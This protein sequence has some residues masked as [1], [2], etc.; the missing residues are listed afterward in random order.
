[1]ATAVKHT[2]LELNDSRVVRFRIVSRAGVPVPI[3]SPGFSTPIDTL[4]MLIN[5]ASFDTD[6]EQSVNPVKTIGGFIILHWGHMPDVI[7]AS[8]TTPA[9]YL[10]AEDIKKYTKTLVNTQNNNA[11]DFAYG[12]T[13]I[14]REFTAGYQNYKK[15][16][17]IFR[18]NGVTTDQF[19]GRI[20]R[21]GVGSVEMIY[22][23][24]IYRG[25]FMTFDE[26]ESAD[27]PYSIDYSFT[28][29]VV[30]EISLRSMRNGFNY[31]EFFVRNFNDNIIG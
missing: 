10:D 30:K 7:S 13:D 19:T 11:R 21:N 4:S 3:T 27:T 28:Y 15:L 31:S 24:T 12:L 2:G 20:D 6:M 29:K 5:P 18:H 14:N 17:D 16:L 25:F 23:N 22:K 1:M 26:K 8:G 9:F